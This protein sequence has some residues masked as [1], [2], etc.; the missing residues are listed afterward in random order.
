MAYSHQLYIY[1]YIYIYISIYQLYNLLLLFRK[2][3]YPQ[4]MSN[5]TSQSHS[6]FAIANTIRHHRI[7]SCIAIYLTY[8]PFTKQ[9]CLKHFLPNSI[10]STYRPQ[11]LLHNSHHM[12]ISSIPYHKSYFQSKHNDYLL[13]HTLIYIYIYIYIHIHRNNSIICLRHILFVHPRQ[14]INIY[15]Y[16][17][18]YISSS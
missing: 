12:Y 9:N 8:L 18:I 1:I 3:P 13:R 2:L 5:T 10:C 6:D 14:Y 11:N 4:S 16:I 17:Y 7:I 15:I